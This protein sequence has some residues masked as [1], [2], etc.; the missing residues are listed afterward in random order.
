MDGGVI[1]KSRNVTGQSTV[2]A[3]SPDGAG[4]MA[5]FTKYNTSTLAVQG[6]YSTVNAPFPFPSGFSGANSLQNLG[7]SVFSPDGST[8]YRAFNQAP[9]TQPPSR[10]LSSILFISDARNLA[11]KLGIR[12]PESIVSRMVITSDGNDAW[13]L[14]ESG[15]LH[16]PLGSL[17]DYPILQPETN[18]VFLAVDDCNRGIASTKLRINNLGKGK[19]TFAV[20][21]LN[22]TLIAQAESGLAPSNLNLTMDP[23]R[24]SGARQPGTNL[25]F[26]SGLSGG[27]T[28]HRPDLAGSDQHPEP[29]PR[30]HE[31]P[32]SDMR[33]IVTPIPTAL[34]GNHGLRDHGT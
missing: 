2:L 28:Q 27:P 21:N 30:L 13:G 9:F 15:M 18:T 5:G 16:L 34:N 24:S 12:L 10:P 17:Y 11:I 25:S 26:N 6:Q 8:I 14:S 33:G 29:H 22:A 3:V 31:L 23:G 32:H 1:L 7:G 20:P 19:L 4:F